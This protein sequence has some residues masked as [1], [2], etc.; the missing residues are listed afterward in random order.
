[1]ST[2]EEKILHTNGSRTGE[3]YFNSKRTVTG[4]S[5]PFSQESSSDPRKTRPFQKRGHF[6]C[7]LKRVPHPLVRSYQT[8]GQCH[9]HQAFSLPP[10]WNGLQDPLNPPL[11]I[12]VGNHFHGRWCA[13]SA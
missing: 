12:G 6:G 11:K 10:F 1:M 4:G 7:L 5:G 9:F 8:T 2:L 13:A 3:R